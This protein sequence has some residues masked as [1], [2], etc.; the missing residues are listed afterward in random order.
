[1]ADRPSPDARQVPPRPIR[2]PAQRLRQRH[3][4]SSPSSVWPTASPP[5]KNPGT[6]PRN[7]EAQRPLQLRTNTSWLTTVIMVGMAG[8]LTATS[9]ALSLRLRVASVSAFVAVA[10]LQ[11]WPRALPALIRG[12]HGTA[13]A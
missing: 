4:P 8:M 13:V 3:P 12:T 6:G 5:C 1:M 7:Q 9:I 2:Y 11:A 10:A